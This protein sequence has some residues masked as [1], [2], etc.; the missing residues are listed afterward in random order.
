MRANTGLVLIS[1]ADNDTT[2]PKTSVPC[3]TKFTMKL[4][5]SDE[6]PFTRASACPVS[7][8]NSRESR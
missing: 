6:A 3:R 7:R 5:S 1:R 8:L 2:S 4:R